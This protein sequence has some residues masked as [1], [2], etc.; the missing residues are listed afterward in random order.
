MS[1]YGCGNCER[2]VRGPYL[3]VAGRCAYD[4]VCLPAGKAA[5]SSHEGAHELRDVTIEIARFVNG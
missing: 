2:Y 5:D 3:C 1:S 4:G